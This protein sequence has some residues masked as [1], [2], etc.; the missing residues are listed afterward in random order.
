MKQFF[1]KTLILII[2]LFTSIN[3]L[4]SD[5][6]VG[7]IH[8][9]I[10]DLENLTCGVTWGNYT[11]DII[12]PETVTYKNQ[13]YTVTGIFDSAFRNCN[14]ESLTIPNS[15]TEINE[16]VFGDECSIPIL[17]IA[18]GDNTL[19]INPLSFT[20][21]HTHELYC[22]RNLTETY[23]KLFPDIIKVTL[24]GSVTTIKDKDFYECDNLESAI[25]GE[26]VE[27][28]DDWAFAYCRNLTAVI[29]GESVETIDSWAFYNCINLLS[30]TIPNSVT[31]IGNY[32][33]R[34]CD[35]LTHV[36]VPN[37]VT[38]ICE[39]AFA[40]CDNLTHVTI[41]N[42]VTIIGD[43]AF[44]GCYNLTSVTIPNSVKT[45]S[46][47]TFSGCRALKSVVISNSV[48]TIGIRA[49]KNCKS[50]TSVTIGESVTTIGAEAF[51]YCNALK[52]INSLNPIPPQLTT[53]FEYGV[54]LNA[55]LK[56]PIGS[57]K[58]Y[59]AMPYWLHFWNIQEVDFA[60]V[61]NIET[62]K[63]KVFGDSG[64]I[65]VTGID[66]TKVE[67]FNTSGQLIYSGSDTTINVPTKGIYIVRVGGE[68]FKVSI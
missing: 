20:K 59:R 48:T 33:F 32:A 55:T 67:I 34:D 24:G 11:G 63:T 2:G 53:P 56:A 28:I 40:N 17:I 26:S 41:P 36:T 6:E 16:G 3:V 15:I 49:F 5:F 10:I 61:G 14:V 4:A 1:H 54:Y 58:K 64:K 45:I 39:G 31:I 21:S 50:L 9:N 7:G 52:T 44:I 35:N 30:V 12:I 42:S 8:Y 27:T 18:D 43:G 68:T 51:D 65:I 19:D 47:E 25:I 29:I 37:S 60:S 38:T 57:G 22:G 62:N 23:A 46:Y 66:N 13:Q